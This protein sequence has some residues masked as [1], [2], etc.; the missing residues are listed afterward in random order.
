MHPTAE[1]LMF[2]AKKLRGA[3]GPSGVARLLNVS[4]QKVTNWLSRGVSKEGMLDAQRL[5]GCNA[6]WLQT[7]EGAMVDA[8]IKHT[9]A[10]T[11]TTK[12]RQ[13]EHMIE[14]SMP[15]RDPSIGN[16]IEIFEANVER[17]D[18]D[19]HRIPLISY[20]QAGAMTE[21]TDPSSL[22]DALEFVLTNEDVSARAFGLRIKDLSCWPEYQEG[23]VVIIEPEIRPDPGNMV[24][25]KG[26][27]EEAVFGKYRPRG[28]N[29]QGEMVFELVPL[30]DD[31][32]T[33]NSERDHL[34]IIGVEIEHH[35]KKRRRQI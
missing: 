5:I 29:D 9:S 14:G 33:L 21:S 2:A 15:A 24:V 31:F 17:I 26:G 28:T 35:R 3:D 12:K 11:Q 13:N 34:Q 1:R 25:V 32:A 18:G 23:D 7:G 6:T 30:N 10:P 19:W 16:S 22:G 20:A 27:S 8:A 4:P